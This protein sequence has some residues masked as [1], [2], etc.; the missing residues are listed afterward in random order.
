[1]VY[2]VFFFIFMYFEE[3][4]AIVISYFCQNPLKKGSAVTLQNVTNVT[5]VTH[6]RVRITS[7]TYN[8][9]RIIMLFI[10][11]NTFF[12]EKIC[13]FQKKVVPLQSVLW[14]RANKWAIY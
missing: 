1:M 14:A 2:L 10:K 11:K 6:F 7:C 5:N 8:E 12:S 13:V 4:Y 3:N 9:R